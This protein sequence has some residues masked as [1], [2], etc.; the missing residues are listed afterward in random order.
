MYGAG[1]VGGVV[2]ARLHQGGHEVVLVARGAHREAIA[3]DGLVLESPEGRTTLRIPVVAAPDGVDWSGEP[4]VLLAV[5]GQHTMTAMEALVGRAPPA[6]PVV[7]AQNG[8][9]NERWVLRHFANTYG[10]CVMCATTYLRPGRVESHYSPVTG[11]LDIGR[12]PRGEDEVTGAV[13]TALRGSTFGSVSRSDIMRWKYRKLLMNLSNAVE[14]LCGPGT[15]A[16]A[17]ARAATSEGEACLRAAQIEFA[18]V[19]E[20]AE[21]RRELSPT[22]EAVGSIGQV[23]RAGGGSTWQSLARGAGSVEVDFLNGEIVL[24]GRLHGV[25]TPVNDLLQRLTVEAIRSAAP[26]GLHSVE[27]LLGRALG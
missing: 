13:A 8:V 23:N 9:D 27:E 2:G 14:A 15:S 1:A 19:E 5:K 3:R 25:G 26:P 24:L 21:R 17:L 7:C 16:S 10:M 12:F 11:L 22:K 6:T 20:D 18:S 4:V